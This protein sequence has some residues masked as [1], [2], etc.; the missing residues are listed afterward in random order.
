MTRTA[1]TLVC[2]LV[3]ALSGCGGDEPAEP[4]GAA[5]PGE[6]PELSTE[7]AGVVTELA[8][9]PEGMA[10]DA[11]TDILA[12]A[13]REPTRLLLIQGATGE[14][15]TEVPLPGHARHLQMG[16]PGG[17]VLVGAEDSNTLVT[18]TLPGGDATATP[19]GDYPHDATRT[20]SGRI[21]VAEEFAGSVSLVEDG[22]VVHRFDGATQPGGVAAVGDLVGMID[23]AEF[24]L[25]VYDAAAEER[26]AGIRAGDGPTHIV[27]DSRG[28]LLVADTRGGA[29]LVFTLDPLFQT[30]RI[31]VP[32][33]PYGLAYDPNRDIVWVTLPVRNEVVGLD[34]SSGLLEEVARLPTVRQ[35]NTVAVDPDSGRVWV[36]SRTTG[37]LQTID[38]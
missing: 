7:P 13:V 30:K 4:L 23:V 32:G 9:Q 25:T 18:V 5:E 38:P 17:P 26:I 21:A 1:A 22:E 14:I 12:V 6:A 20:E 35:P 29:I 16:G 24:S 28:D 15:L 36:S 10:Y 19:V 33:N 31:A 2:A 27:A 8:L 11:E 37:Q 34:A 3:L